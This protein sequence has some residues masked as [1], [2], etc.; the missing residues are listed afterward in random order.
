MKIEIN[1]KQYVAERDL[2]GWSLRIPVIRK[3]RKTKEEK[4]DTEVR[5][6]GNLEQLLKSIADREAGDCKE[7]K[8]VITL[9]EKFPPQS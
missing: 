5:Y 4:E 8:D 9:L 3:D 1:G 2:N 6:F 7:L